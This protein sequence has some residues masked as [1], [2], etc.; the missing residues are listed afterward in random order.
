MNNSTTLSRRSSNKLK[1]CCGKLQKNRVLSPSSRPHMAPFNPEHQGFA[2][3]TLADLLACIAIV[4]VLVGL[5]MP[6]LN[7]A[8]ERAYAVTCMNNQRQIGVGFNIYVADESFFPIATV[9][10]GLG[11]WQRALYPIIGNQVTCPK[12][13]KISPELHQNFT[14]YSVLNPPYGYNFDGSVW[15]NVPPFCLG[16]GGYYQNGSYLPVSATVIKEPSQF[17]LLG[18]CPAVLPISGIAPTSL[19]PANLLAIFSPYTFPEF[20]APGVAAW[21]FDG[22]YVLFYS[23]EVKFAKQSVLMAANDTERSLF[24]NDFQPDEKYW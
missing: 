19:T 3:F 4:S 24:N 15:N 2:G 11:N 21:H 14:T 16:A 8:K 23:G 12:S 20:N 7:H 1:P 10:D 13:E 22:S 6:A 5:L 17:I 18:D 9:G